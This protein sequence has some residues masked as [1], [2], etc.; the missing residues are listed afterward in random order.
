M[1]YILNMVKKY[2]LIGLATLLP[3][4][5]TFYVVVLIFQFVD[6]LAGSHLNT[7]IFSQLGFKIPGLGIIVTLILLICTGMVASIFLGRYLF[8]VFEKVIV[9]VP[10]IASIY[11]SA[12]QFTD[13][14]FGQQTKK[15]FQKVVLVE[16][17]DKG[18]YSIAFVTNEN[19][20]GIELNGQSNFICVFIPYP[21][22]PFSGAMLLLPPEKVFYIDL[23][24]DD[25]IKFIISGGIVAPRNF[26]KD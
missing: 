19:I 8:P 10:I 24:I 21:P 7:L 17:P 23:P 22:T 3:I 14:L 15:S 2:L 6:N 20:N 1:K 18:S 11:P 16:Y 12:K 4:F 5:I 25:A 9:K 13:F 26:I